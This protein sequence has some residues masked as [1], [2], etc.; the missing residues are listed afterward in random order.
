M[1]EYAKLG[2]KMSLIRCKKNGKWGWKWGAHGF[3]Y[4][5]RG[6]LELA[7]RDGRLAEKE[8]AINKEQDNAI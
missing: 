6:A 1:F 3:C 5:C 7:K 4:T 8:M 2:K